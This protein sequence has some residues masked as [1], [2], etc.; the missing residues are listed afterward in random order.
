MSNN[1]VSIE[2]LG[3]AVQEQQ[4]SITAKYQDIISSLK[5]ELQAQKV[6][7]NKVYQLAQS[8]NEELKQQSI[9]TEI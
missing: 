3:S 2:A 1:A 7:T 4:V 8:I 9:R 6:K 5:S